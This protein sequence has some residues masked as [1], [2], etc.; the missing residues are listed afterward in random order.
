MQRTQDCCSRTALPRVTGCSSEAPLM[1]WTRST[2]KTKQKT[3]NWKHPC[4]SFPIAKLNW[5]GNKA[6]LG[7]KEWDTF[8]SVFVPDLWC[9]FYHSKKII[10]IV[11]SYCSIFLK[12]LQ[13]GRPKAEILYLP[14]KQAQKNPNPKAQRSVTLSH[15]CSERPMC[16]DIIWEPLR[17]AEHDSG[18][19]MLKF[20]LSFY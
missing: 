10:L 4:A 6:V 9:L 8:D 3:V 5:T 2:A 16:L 12:R 14:A 15:L 11:Q 7:L 20:F 1:N 17:V 19:A 13:R 18:K